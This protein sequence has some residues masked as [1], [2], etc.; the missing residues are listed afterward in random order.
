VKGLK[1]IHSP[2]TGIIDWGYVARHYGKMYEQNGGKVVL[3]F[4]ADKFEQSPDP[5]YPLRITAKNSVILIINW[6]F[7]IIL[8]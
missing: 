7:E 4:E 5:N 1:A 2:N 3:N 6:I 8:S